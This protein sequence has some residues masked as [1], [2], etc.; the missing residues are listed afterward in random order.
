MPAQFVRPT[1]STPA[2]VPSDYQP[3]ALSSPADPADLL[4]EG[5]R[6]ILRDLREQRD[7][8][9]ADVL[10]ISDQ[11]AEARSELAQVGNRVRQLRAGKVAGGFQ[12][13]ED[14]PVVAAEAEKE[15]KIS[16]KI[17]ELAA[18]Q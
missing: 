9:Q 17:A 15:R 4:P 5:P 11:L 10:R 3:R 18:R 8:A 14:H 1:F 16:A 13:D 2:P 6:E 7:S 12:L